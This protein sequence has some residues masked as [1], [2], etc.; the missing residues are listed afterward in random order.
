MRKKIR[1]FNLVNEIKDFKFNSFEEFENWINSVQE[2][3]GK[4]FEKMEKMS[5][6]EINSISLPPPRLREVMDRFIP[7]MD[8]MN[9]MNL[10]EGMN[11]NLGLGDQTTDEDG[12]P[13]EVE[14]IH[15]QEGKDLLTLLTCHPYASGG[16]FRYLVFCQRKK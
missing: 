5:E 11:L 9:T 8:K 4:N 13:I 14:E 1:C 2:K 15:I 10:D 3:L 12:K 6:E 16:K 7:D